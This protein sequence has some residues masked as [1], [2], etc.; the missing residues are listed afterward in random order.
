MRRRRYL[1]VIPAT[2]SVGLASCTSPP[3]PDWEGAQA[4]ADA[5]I[6]TAGTSEDFLGAG[7]LRATQDGEVPLDGEGITLDYPSEVRVDGFRA[8]CFGG[9]EA[10]FG[11]LVRAESS[12]SGIDPLVLTCDGEPRTV[13]LD[14]PFEHINAIRLNGRVEDTA[15]AL[16]AAALTGVT[17]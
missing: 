14:T 2:L 4:Q 13:S 5:F 10:T 17:Q 1:L 7:T 3:A 16:I 9:G 12:W 6:E 15:G 8:V 11:L